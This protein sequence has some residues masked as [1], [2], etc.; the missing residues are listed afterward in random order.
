MNMQ[1]LLQKIFAGQTS[2]DPSGSS[3]PELH[4][5]QLIAALILKAE[6]LG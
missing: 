4:A 6:E 3:E 1:Q 2:F 5:F